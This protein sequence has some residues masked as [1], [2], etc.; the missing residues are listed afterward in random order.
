MREASIVLHKTHVLGAA[1]AQQGSGTSNI[2][3]FTPP[4]RQALLLVEL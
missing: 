1:H 4:L 2:V 3:R